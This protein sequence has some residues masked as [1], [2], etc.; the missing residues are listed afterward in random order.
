MSVSITTD[1]QEGG[2]DCNRDLRYVWDNCNE[3]LAVYGDRPIAVYEGKVVR[4]ASRLRDLRRRLPPELSHATTGTI[5]DL[6]IDARAMIRAEA[7]AAAH[8]L[9]HNSYS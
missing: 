7:R 2:Y 9:S 5:E 8:D 6:T 4:S 3:L 1:G